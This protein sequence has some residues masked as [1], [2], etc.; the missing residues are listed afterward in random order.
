MRAPTLVPIESNESS[1]TIR[2]G[3]EAAA[4]LKLLLEINDE[5][6]E[7]IDSTGKAIQYFKPNK[8]RS[9]KTTRNFMPVTESVRANILH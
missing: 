7:H 2:L 8:T 5:M 4:D 1:C 6:I 3:K 9:T